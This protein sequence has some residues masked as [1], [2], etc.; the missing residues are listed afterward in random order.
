MNAIA[1]A[2]DAYRAARKRGLKECTASR[3]RGE[4]GYLAVPG[5]CREDCG[6]LG[7]IQQPLRQVSLNRVVGTYQVNRAN[8]FAPNFMPILPETSEFAAKWISLYASHLELGVRDAIRVYEYLWRYYVSEGNKRVSVLK[9]VGASAFDAEITRLIPQYDEENPEIVRYYAFLEYAKTGVFSDIELSDG[10]KYERLLELERKLIG[11]LPA[12]ET[13]NCNQIYMRFET[14]YLKT[15]CTM[16]L[17]D[18]FLEYLQLYGLPVGAFA[19]EMAERIRLLKPQLDIVEH[20][21]QPELVLEETARE[22]P[23]LSRLIS[24][25][26]NPN[27]VFVYTPGRTQGNWLGAHEAGRLAMQQELGEQVT[28]R[29]IDILDRDAVYEQLTREAGD[30]GLLFAASPSLMTP[31]LRFALEHPCCVSL[32]YSRMQHDY[33]LHTYFGRYY[34]AMFV[35]GYLAGQ[36]SKNGIVCYITPRLDDA[37]YTSD[38]NAFAIGAR[39]AR[40]DIRV[41]LMTRGVLPNDPTTCTNAMSLAGQMGVDVVF[42]QHYPS[43]TLPDLPEDALSVMVGIDCY[44]MPTRYLAAPDWNWARFYTAI[45]RSYLNGSLGALLDNSVDGS[46]VKSFWWGIG[47]GIIDVRMNETFTGAGNNV[48]RFL[49]GSIARNTFNPFHGPMIDKEGVV[50]VAA[51]ANPT[52]ADVMNMRY[53]ADFI[54]LVE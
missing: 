27:I 9:F 40:P 19:D 6:V 52:P 7:F 42:T 3:A 39:S 26:K 13:P 21:A 25:H 45:V 17:G 28:S 47:A 36:H 50:R 1:D 15:D 24:G 35:C 37:R 4:S 33:R 46:P 22:R 54:E 30:A 51:H 43:L 29:C 49:K 48:A 41:L 44:G 34:E 38:I 8:S 18:A 31:V 12:G 16:T 53:L 32:I 23:L 20:P 11:E 2:R 14:A 10:R 5:V